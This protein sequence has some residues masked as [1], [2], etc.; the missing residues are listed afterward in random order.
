MA[1]EKKTESEKRGGKKQENPGESEKQNQKRRNEGHT[2]QA[3]W[4]KQR[5]ENQ[6]KKRQQ[7]RQKS[8]QKQETKMKTGTRRG[9]ADIRKYQHWKKNTQLKRRKANMPKGNQLILSLQAIRWV[10][11]VLIMTMTKNNR[12]TMTI[13]LLTSTHQWMDGW[14]YK[15]N[16]NT[17]RQEVTRWQR[18]VLRHNGVEALQDERNKQEERKRKQQQKQTLKWRVEK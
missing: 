1:R 14:I 18:W 13:L 2:N 11:G 4:G 16:M 8:K 17:T 6:E 9:N 12:Q 3:Q 15:T 5:E 7:Q 10:L